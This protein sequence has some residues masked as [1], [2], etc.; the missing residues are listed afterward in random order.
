MNWRVLLAGLM[1]APAVQAAEPAVLAGS[2]QQ[3]ALIVA[4]VEPGSHVWFNGEPLRVAPDGVFALGLHRDAPPAAELKVRTPAGAEQ[5]HEYVVAQ[6]RYAVQ[7]LDGLPDAMVSPPPAVQARID[8][9]ARR[10]AEAR[11]LDR[12]ATDFAT[13]FVWPVNGRIS[14]VYGSQRI[15]NGEPRQPHY[16]IDIAAATG[17]PV[18]AAAAGVVQLADTDLYYTGGTLIVDHGA[19]VSSTYLHLSTLR[20]AQGEAVRAGQVIGAVGATGRV[21][22]PHLCLRFNW[23]DARLDPQLLL[24]PQAAVKGK[25]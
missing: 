7:H 23:R 8:D 2:W 12:A 1:M 22:G 18:R 17:T 16:G 4:R 19:G 10:V 5:R 9:D 24:P 15:L 25:R 6:R 21:T 13:G 14:S 3:G 11:A 20:V